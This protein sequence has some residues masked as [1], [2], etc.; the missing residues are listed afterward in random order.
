MNRLG[1][2]QWAQL[3][4]KDISRQKDTQKL[5]DIDCIGELT[6]LMYAAKH[7][8]YR[9]VALLIKGGADLNMQS[10]VGN[11]ALILAAR[12]GAAESVSLLLAAGPKVNLQ[13]HS[14]HTA[15]MWASYQG[16]ESIKDQLLTCG[17]D[18]D[19]QNEYG[20]TAMVLGKRKVS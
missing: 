8:Q 15:L 11:T 4:R 10:N 14:N 7:N 5:F 3:A 17:A 18:V 1:E 9:V 19:L 2:N 12:K 20:E 16:Y 6:P 13:T